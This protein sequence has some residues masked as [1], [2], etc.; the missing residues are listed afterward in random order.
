MFPIQQR[1]ETG[2]HKNSKVEREEGELSP[3]GDF[4]EENFGRLGN[5]ADGASRP[6]EVSAGRPRAAEFAGENDADVDEEGEESAQRSTEDSE[7]ASEAGEDASG[8]ESGDGEE[9]SREDHE[10]EEDADHDAKAES[11]GEAEANTEAHDADGGISLPFSERLHNAVK[12]LAKH[13]PTALHDREEK[14]SRI[15]YG[16]DSFYVLFRLHQVSYPYTCMVM[17]FAY[18]VNA[19]WLTCINCRSYMREYYQ[20]RQTL[21]QLKRSGELLRIQTPHTNIQSN[22]APLLCSIGTFLCNG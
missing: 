9:C 8:S 1:G 16:N 2:P 6:K 4:E 13:V 15:F 22:I 12:P 17:L 20:L 10:D 7:N 11:E 3:N 21:L 14:F 5:V 19:L 18:M